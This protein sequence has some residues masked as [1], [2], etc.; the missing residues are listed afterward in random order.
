MKE[1]GWAR[2]R[3]ILNLRYWFFTKLNQICLSREKERNKQGEDTDWLRN[4]KRKR[5]KTDRQTDIKKRNEMRIHGMT[6]T[7]KCL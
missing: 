4:K 1:V 7:K 2:N 5:E 6:D 3:T